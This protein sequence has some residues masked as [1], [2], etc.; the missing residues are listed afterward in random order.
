MEEA[1]LA[2]PTIEA[3]SSGHSES[4]SPKLPDGESTGNDPPVLMRQITLA[5]HRKRDVMKTT[6]YKTL[7]GETR[8]VT[9]YEA[10]EELFYQSITAGTFRVVVTGPGH[11]MEPGFTP[12][13]VTEALNLD[14]ITHRF[15]PVGR[16]FIS[17]NE[18]LFPC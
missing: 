14:G 2:L 11:P 17:A 5:T 1:S 12:V 13:K 10:G 3:D 8:S 6:T 16:E 7:L 15:Y 4:Q 18:H 9:R